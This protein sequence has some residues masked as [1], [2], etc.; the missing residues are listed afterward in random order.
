MV[1][2]DRGQERGRPAGIFAVESGRVNKPGLYEI[3]M[4][5][6][7]LRELI[8]DHCGGMRNG[9]KVKAVIPGGASTPFLSADELDVTLDFDAIQAKGSFMGSTAVIVMDETTCMVHASLILTRFF[10]HESCG[11]CTPCREGTHWAETILERFEHGGARKEDM[12]ILLDIAAEMGGGRT[13]CALADGAIGPIKSTIQK[14][15]ADYEA[16]IPG[17]CPQ[18]GELCEVSW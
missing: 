6:V 3:E 10:A 12:D 5:K 15:R 18:K 7:T 14:W 2:L 1:R 13:I 16:H 17:G 8:E 4:G 9:R 11:Q